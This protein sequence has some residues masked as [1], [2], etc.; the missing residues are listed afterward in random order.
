MSVPLSRSLPSASTAAQPNLPAVTLPM[1]AQNTRK[2]SMVHTDIRSARSATKNCFL[3]Q[4]A[5]YD[6][7]QRQKK[8]KPIVLRRPT[9]PSYLYKAEVRDVID[10]DTSSSTST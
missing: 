6:F 7:A 1:S 8:G 2:P 9:D 3:L 5:R 10:A 4:G